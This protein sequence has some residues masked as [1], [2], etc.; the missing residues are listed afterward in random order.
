MAMD[1][2]YDLA[3]CELS[4][5]SDPAKEILAGAE[6]AQAALPEAAEEDEEALELTPASPS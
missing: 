1:S 2:W 3:I 4:D 6:Q 5:L